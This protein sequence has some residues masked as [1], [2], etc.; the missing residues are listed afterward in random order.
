MKGMSMQN[1]VRLSPQLILE[2]AEMLTRA[3]LEGKSV[4]FQTGVNGHGRTWVKYDAGGGWT[5]PLYG[6]DW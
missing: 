4:R 2:F 6:L 3:D 1:I 5:P